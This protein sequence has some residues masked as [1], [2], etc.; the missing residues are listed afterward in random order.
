MIYQIVYLG[1][2]PF[3]E[4]SRQ[5]LMAQFP[6]LSEQQIRNKIQYASKK[7]IKSERFIKQNGAITLI[8]LRFKEWFLNQPIES[9]LA[10]NPT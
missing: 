9:Y 10:N 3:G 7:L 8:D 2:K 4:Q 6:D 1:G 5:F